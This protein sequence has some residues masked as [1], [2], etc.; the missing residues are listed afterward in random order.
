MARRD[1][2][3]ASEI[4]AHLAIETERLI[5]DGLTP[6]A[7]ARTAARRFGNRTTAQ[8][9]FY[10]SRRILWVDELWQDLR[11]AWRALRR[12]PG[13][14][15][16][17]ILTLVVGIGANTAIFSVVNAV[18]L[19]PL[20]YREPGSLMLIETA[21]LVLS[22]PWLT[23][24]WRERAGTLS[25]LA[26][27]NGPRSAT[28]IAG[29]EPAPIDSAHVTWNFFSF[30][31]VTPAAG[32]EFVESDGLPR[33]VPV[34]VITHELW[35]RQFGG[36]QDVV[37]RS[38][39]L[40]RE[41]VTVIGV[42]PREFRFPTGGALPANA[43]PT[44]TQ[45][46]VIRVA[47]PTA[48][49]NV[50]GRLESATG[51]DAA[52]TE[53]L[54]IFKQEATSRFP[55]L[56]D[57]L[58]LDA[59]L[60][61]DRLVGDVRQ[62]LRLVMGAVIFVLLVACANVA[63]LLLARASTRQR[64][65][66]LR[67]AI[68]AR[69]G[70]LVRLLLTESLLLALIGA[71]GGLLLAYATSGIARTLLAARVPH[72]D[73]IAIDWW[74]LGFSVAV[75]GVTGVAS[76]LASIPGATRVNLATIFSATATPGVTGRSAVRRALLSAEVAVTFVLVIG[77]ALLV[78]TVWNLSVKERGFQADRLLTVRVAPGLPP[79]LDPKD[80]RAGD[81]YFATF[82]TDL[83]QQMA[84]V[85][86]IAGAA[87]VS[88]VPF[89]GLGASMGGL[90]VDGQAPATPDEASAFVAAV[91]PGYFRTMGIALAAGR[92][93]DDRDR[94]GAEKVAIVNEA[95][96][97]RFA[98]DGNIVGSAIRADKNVITIVGV[99]GDVPE[100][101]LREAPE[102]VV[103]FALQQMPMHPFGWG[104]LRMVL[105]TERADP[106]AMAATIRR[107]IWA[108]DRN[109]VIDEFATMDER[110]AATIRPERDSAL[111]FGLFAVAALIMAAV[112]VYGV[113]AYTLELR[114]REIGI[115]VALGADRRAVSRLVLSQ[116]L[117]PT[118]IGI[119]VGIAA[120]AMAT[121][122]VASMIY[123]V[124]PLDPATF[125]GTAVVLAGVAMAASFV[126]LRRA[127]RMNPL[128]ALRYE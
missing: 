58:E 77:A 63:N 99:A 45:P 13:F 17:A 12:S 14:A 57:R 118:A 100:R 90:T 48:G 3:F 83:T 66:A 87:A 113:A 56:V 114:T 54:A 97:R 4:E 42:A 96:R 40:D 6:E 126:P 106:L 41:R 102:P 78:Q 72:V 105:R 111:L 125:V 85:P 65:L 33:A 50:I 10:E 2:D 74:V 62:R 24:A 101:T 59:G 51:P 25:D 15:C 80:P 122:L 89:A 29:G 71:A 70:R 81:K 93:F 7:A 11:Y 104:A 49:L 86:G 69:K 127:L 31:G 39:T 91:S 123:G 84:R 23:A 79:G 1:D 67:A 103:F 109:I 110:M 75:A 108:V 9:R 37:G 27:F 60:L 82:F 94:L 88:S 120:A 21:P 30:L 117:W 107:A 124:T 61:Q 47:A 28:L 18:L 22:P 112:G 20:P 38:V 26:G 116:N 52:R 43:L 32:R 5:A 19:R 36:A 64:E 55:R 119:A 35:M 115:R 76:G 68:G 34:A 44:D 95:F 8:E 16:V 53:L 128:V 46:D 121:R 73:G 98:P 92:D